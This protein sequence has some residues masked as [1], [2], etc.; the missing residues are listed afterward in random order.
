MKRAKWISALMLLFIPVIAAAQIHQTQQIA[1]QV[2]FQFTVG[3]VTIPAGEIRVQVADQQGWVLRVS[4]RDTQRS[5]FVSAVPSAAGKAAQ[6]SAL[7]FRKYGDQYFLTGMKVERSQA[8]YEFRQS[9]LEKE[10]GAQNVT[11]TEQILLGSAR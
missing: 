6:V 8:V 2:P 7:V 10:L 9:K 4:N 1:A 5:F 3:N 11:P